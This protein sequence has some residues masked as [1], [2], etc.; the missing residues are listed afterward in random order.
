ML[1]HY[2]PVHGDEPETFSNDLA[3]D[4]FP[5]GLLDNV[6]DILGTGRQFFNLPSVGR[7]QP[8]HRGQVLLGG[9]C[10]VALP[11]VPWSSVFSRA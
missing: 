1:K 9:R 8:S 7:V 4:H 10:R 11:W 2:S 6:A 3:T 5:A